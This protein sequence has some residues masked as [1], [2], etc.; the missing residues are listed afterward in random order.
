MAA[1]DL[2]L[3]VQWTVALQAIPGIGG[4]FGEPSWDDQVNVCCELYDIYIHTI[5]ETY[6]WILYVV[7]IC[8]CIIYIY[9]YS[10]VYIYILLVYICIYIYV[11]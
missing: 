2:R 5:V 3:R 4:P 10:C 11:M 9:I 8:T 7:Y 6:L 1:Q